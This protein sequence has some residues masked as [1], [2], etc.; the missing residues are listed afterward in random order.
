MMNLAMLI[1]GMSTNFFRMFGGLRQGRVSSPLL[2][3]L[4]IDG[5][6]RGIRVANE[7]GKIIGCSVTRN[8]SVSHLMFIDDVLYY[9]ESKILEW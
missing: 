6:N 7:A 9:G 5:L 8:I 2:F 1:N 4:V 3:I